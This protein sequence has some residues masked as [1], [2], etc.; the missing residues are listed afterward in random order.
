[1]IQAFSDWCGDEATQTIIIEWHLPK[2]GSAGP[3]QHKIKLVLVKS[4]SGSQNGL[5]GVEV[6][7]HTQGRD[8]GFQ[9]K[10][11]VAHA[12]PRPVTK[13]LRGGLHLGLKLSNKF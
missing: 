3:E 4:E 10:G 8:Q 6:E 2:F 12:H 13:I 7:D 5:Q 9:G 11:K 1:M